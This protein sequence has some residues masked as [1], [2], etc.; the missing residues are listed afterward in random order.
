MLTSFSPIPQSDGSTLARPRVLIAA[1][2]KGKGRPQSKIDG[3]RP[4]S[5]FN[6]DGVWL[7]E[8]HKLDIS[9][10]VVEAVLQHYRAT[11]GQEIP[12][13]THVGWFMNLLKDCHIASQPPYSYAKAREELKAYIYL[14]SHRRLLRSIRLGQKDPLNFWTLLTQGPDDFPNKLFNQEDISEKLRS[15]IPTPCQAN[16]RKVWVLHYRPEGFSGLTKP[17]AE[18]KLSSMPLYDPAGRRILHLLFSTLL[19]SILTALEELST[20]LEHPELKE[21]E[22]DLRK[23]KY[24]VKRADVQITVFLDFLVIFQ[25]LLSEHLNWL[26][27]RIPF[28]SLSNRYTALRN[29]P[30]EDRKDLKELYR[31]SNQY[32]DEKTGRSGWTTAVFEWLEMIV[33]IEYE[34]GEVCPFKQGHKT[35]V[36]GQDVRNMEVVVLDSMETYLRKGEEQ[37]GA[38]LCRDSEAAVLDSIFGDEGVRCDRKEVETRLASFPTTT[39]SSTGTIHFEALI[40]SSILLLKARPSNVHPTACLKQKSISSTLLPI[41]KDLIRNPS[42]LANLTKA[43]CCATCTHLLSLTLEDNILPSRAKDIFPKPKP[44][45]SNWHNTSSLP[46]FLPKKYKQSCLTQAKL[47]AKHKLNRLHKIILDERW[48]EARRKSA[49]LTKPRAYCLKP[50]SGRQ[51]T[52][53]PYVEEWLAQAKIEAPGRT[54]SGENQRDE[55]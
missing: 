9:Q 15:R 45:T 27:L 48:T 36:R 6:A 33:S 17:E 19:R 2:L 24:L 28:E 38:E 31:L 37:Q 18:E 22:E 46:P 12:F 35:T 41:L 29:I 11:K 52:P 8:D 7:S 13:P 34:I 51:S 20:A 50:G 49:E 1:D 26:S 43:P 10:G 14:S 23:I 25:K 5:E 47:E 4:E 42:A 55:S 44:G 32:H 16:F 54:S 53:N 30:S 21:K 40:L 3:K 39:S